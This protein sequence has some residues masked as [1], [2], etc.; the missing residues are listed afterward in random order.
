MTA[1]GGQGTED[2][3]LR[4]GGRLADL[5][6]NNNSK[7]SDKWQIDGRRSKYSPERWGTVFKYNISG[8]CRNMDRAAERRRRVR[9]GI[10]FLFPL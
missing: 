9:E 10:G 2:R 7:D 6:G 4:P 5:S 8:L 1:G 3:K